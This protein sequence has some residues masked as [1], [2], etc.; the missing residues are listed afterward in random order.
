[1]LTICFALPLEIFPFID[2]FHVVLAQKLIHFEASNAEKLTKFRVTPKTL[3][4]C[5]KSKS[6][7][8]KATDFCSETFSRFSRDL[9]SN[10]TAII[11]PAPG[12]RAPTSYTILVKIEL[13]RVPVLS[14][15][16][17]SSIP[18]ERMMLR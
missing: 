12:R 10:H 13:P 2:E 18:I 11:P 14:E 6:L 15:K 1:M 16:D 3:A 17:S 7:A 9:G 4:I 5:F 8:G